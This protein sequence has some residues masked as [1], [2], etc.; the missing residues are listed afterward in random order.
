[1]IYICMLKN[2]ILK[3]ERKYV[4]FYFVKIYVFGCYQIIENDKIKI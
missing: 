2:V 3:K 1:M 4:F